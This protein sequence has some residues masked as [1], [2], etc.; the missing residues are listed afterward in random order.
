[1]LKEAG[2]FPQLSAPLLCLGQQAFPKG[3]AVRVIPIIKHFQKFIFLFSSHDTQQ[4]PTW[5]H[6]NSFLIKKK[7]KKNADQRCTIS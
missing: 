6:E 5:Y 4:V 3:P 2:C 1:M 7:E